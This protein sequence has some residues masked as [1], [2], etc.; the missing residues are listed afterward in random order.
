[1]KKLKVEVI[2]C[3]KGTYHGMVGQVLGVE[4]EN[5]EVFVNVYFKEEGR[6]MYFDPKELREIK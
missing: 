2:G 3:E 1:M 6:R 5:K 4:T